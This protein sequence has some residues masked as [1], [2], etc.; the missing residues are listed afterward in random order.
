[1]DN[2]VRFRLPVCLIAAMAGDSTTA[3]TLLR[4]YYSS[5]LEG[6]AGDRNPTGWFSGAYYDEWTQSPHPAQPEE[7]T[8][9]DILA[10]SYLSA[11]IEGRAAA[12]ILHRRR[13]EFNYFLAEA[14]Q[15]CSGYASLS[16][17]PLEKTSY[18]GRI[19]LLPDT[20]WAPFV[21]EKKL[22]EVDG[23]GA[24]RASKLIARKLPHIYPIYDERVTALTGAR[25]QYLR[26]LHIALVEDPGIEQMLKALR[27]A[28]G[29]RESISA[30]RV[31]DVLAWMEQTD[32]L[33]G[34]EKYKLVTSKDPCG[35]SLSPV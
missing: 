11:P 27:E 18:T 12:V 29:L 34:S 19:K 22:R 16:Q 3:E 10:A 2:S 7:F 8:A 9:E 30:L 13:E 35:S 17:V 31:F 15:A 24:V 21:L 1:M 6:D 5:R 4:R 23:I 32:L 28:V 26:P 20:A 25:E 33:R 14:V